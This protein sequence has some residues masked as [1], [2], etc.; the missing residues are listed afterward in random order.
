MLL[1]SSN[2]TF[3]GNGMRHIW[4]AMSNFIF[5]VS[6][7]IFLHVN[8]AF[9]PLPYAAR[10][11]G[12]NCLHILCWIATIQVGLGWNIG[13]K[14]PWKTFYK[15][16]GIICCLHG[17]MSKICMTSGITIS[18]AWGWHRACIITCLLCRWYNSHEEHWNMLAKSELQYYRNSGC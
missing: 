18:W 7:R 6:S 11:V 10:I 16:A 5:M 13:L 9:F 1:L 2:M 4:H 12:D 17:R 8:I 15:I 3:C 14:R